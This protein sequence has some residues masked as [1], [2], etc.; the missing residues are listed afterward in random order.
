M[1]QMYLQ[2][3][4]NGRSCFIEFQLR[5]LLNYILQIVFAMKND[6]SASFSCGNCTYAKFA[7]RF[8]MLKLFGIAKFQQVSVGGKR[9]DSALRKLAETR[10][11]RTETMRKPY[12]FLSFRIV[13]ALL[14]RYFHPAA[15]TR[16]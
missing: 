6:V 15:V 5:K 10:T 13:S 3:F 4:Y 9:L 11:F 7:N 16:S 8:C 12:E 2:D 1:Y 14:K